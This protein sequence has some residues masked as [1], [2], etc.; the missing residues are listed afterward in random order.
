M[1]NAFEVVGRY[2]IE[3]ADKV[4]SQIDGVSNSARKSSSELGS[5]ASSANKASSN[6][7][8]TGKSA[9]STAKK[10]DRA[11]KSLN[12]FGDSVK[13]TGDRMTLMVSGPLIAAGAGAIKLAKDFANTADSLLDA[14]AATGASTDAIQQWKYVAK[15]AGTSTKVFED[16]VMRINRMMPQ[17]E[18]GTGATSEAVARLGLDAKKFAG[19][20]PSKTMLQIVNALQRVED[21]AKRAEIGTALF[22]RR[23]E[24]LAPVV[25]LGEKALSNFM[26]T[27]SKYAHS[28]A[29]LQK[30]NNFRMA[31]ERLG[32]AF[33]NAKE[34]LAIALMPILNDQFVNALETSVVPAVV[35]LIAGLANLV[36]AFASL[37]APIQSMI[38]GALG[39][40]VVVGPLLSIFGRL[41]KIVSSFRGAARIAITAFNGIRVALAVLS[42]PVGLAVI[43][44]IS[45]IILVFK[46]WG[47]I[48]DFVKKMWEGFISWSSSAFSR[49]SSMIVGAI[50]GLP[51]A[52]FGIFKSAGD[53]VMA[54]LKPFTDSV[55]KTFRNMYAKI[56]GAKLSADTSALADS[57][58]SNSRS[59]SS[60]RSSSSSSSS[61]GQSSGST[62]VDMRNS[63]FRDD[64][65]MLDRLRRQGKGLTGGGIS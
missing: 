55:V 37:P 6:L 50:K 59:S 7:K 18:K 26:K 35:S 44:G 13:R 28:N 51:S 48:S 12:K 54:W 58:A 57:I 34:K 21:P 38:V 63:V 30:S 56:T 19:Q 33:T 4:R 24:S 52:I 16:S 9:E 2:I 41:I 32:A 60:R 45:A 36:K 39:F 23:W 49:M 62:Y 11:S 25:D 61:L 43:A 10:I 27:G 31:I 40:V 29:D 17:F 22:S 3:G 65:D 14:A 46:N 1:A 64:R 53:R 15:Q 47:S 8:G 42:G 20:D 5:T